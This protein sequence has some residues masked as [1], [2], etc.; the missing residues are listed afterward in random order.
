M[1]NGKGCKS[2]VSNHKAY[3]ESI[4]RIFGKKK[5][6]KVEKSNDIGYNSGQKE[7]K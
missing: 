1:S 5:K 4:E 7:P 6:N 3:R 2:R